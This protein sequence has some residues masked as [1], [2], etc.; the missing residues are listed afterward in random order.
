MGATTGISW[1]DSTFNPHRGCTKVSDGCKFC[2]AERDSKRNLKVLGEWGPNGTRVVASEAKWKEPVKW[3]REAAE[4]FDRIGDSLHATADM[5]AE[6][7]RRPRVFCASL[8]DVFETWDGPMVNAKGDDLYL[9]RNGGWDDRSGDKDGHRLKVTMQDVRARLF[10]LIDATPNLD[11]L[12]LTKRPENIAAM[13]PERNAAADRSRAGEVV[14]AAD[15]APG[16]R[17]NVW[18]GTSVENQQ[19]AD[20]RIPHLLRVPAA[21]RFLSC[22]PLLGPVELSNLSGRTDAVEQW[23][24]QS[25]EGIQWVIVGG[26]SGAKART[27]QPAWA[28]MLRDQCLPQKVAYFFKQ[29]GTPHHL[30]LADLNAMLDAGLNAGEHHGGDMLDGRQWHEFP[31]SLA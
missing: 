29:W 2:Y 14:C 19:T 25:L 5:I 3:N 24:R 6:A 30:P 26:E 11:W 12:V 21:V 20:E 22:E 4:R 7:S 23:G 31:R 1:C 8:G 13:M 16:V 18:L 10:R 9:D 28:R 15:F 27:M 17:P